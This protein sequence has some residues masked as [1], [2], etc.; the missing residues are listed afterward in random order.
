MSP[1]KI[2][3]FN[4]NNLLPLHFFPGWSS[5]SRHKNVLDV[6]GLNFSG[7]QAHQLTTTGAKA[8]QLINMKPLPGYSRLCLLAAL[9]LSRPDSGHIDAEALTPNIMCGGAV[10]TNVCLPRYALSQQ[11]WNFY[12]KIDPA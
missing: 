4:S 2:F 12:L 6:D 10:Q 7:K 5:S 9:L 11:T 1:F 3:R 8:D